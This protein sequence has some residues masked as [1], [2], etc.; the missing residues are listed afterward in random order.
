MLQHPLTTLGCVV[1]D[2]WALCARQLSSSPNTTFAMVPWHAFTCLALWCQAILLA[3]FKKQG[4]TQG[5]MGPF[6]A[7][8]AIAIWLCRV[9]LVPESGS[10]RVALSSVV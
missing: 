7:V 9:S 10:S 3:G 5:I 6:G 2:W 1:L 8:L 4:S